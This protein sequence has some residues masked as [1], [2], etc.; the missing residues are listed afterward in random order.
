MDLAG[1]ISIAGKPGLYKVIGQGKN[2][3]IVESLEDAKRIPAHANNKISALEDISIYAH[4]E[5]KPLKDVFASIYKK[6]N[7]KATLSHKE[8]QQKLNSYLEEIFPNYDK[9]RVYPSDIKKVFQWYNLL[10]KA[11]LLKV[12]EEMPKKDNKEEKETPS[13][14]TVA[15]KTTLP[16]KKAT[17]KTTVA[18]KTK[19]APAKK[20]ATTQRKSGK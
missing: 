9:E 12:E 11:N 8:N 17:P 18:A 1:I 13:K 10:L 2:N 4:D 3:V 20:P 15:K 14:K 16:D 6:E 19:S 7:G 5:D